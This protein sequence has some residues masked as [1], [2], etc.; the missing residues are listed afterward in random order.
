MLM[1]RLGRYA[2]ENRLVEEL[3]AF[4]A[5]HELPPM[6]LDEVL[7]EYVWQ[8]IEECANASHREL[9]ESA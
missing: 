2:K 1:D 6:G 9:D 3:R 5:A 7:E 8:H 4:V